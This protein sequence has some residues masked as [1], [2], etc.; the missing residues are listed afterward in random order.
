M[1]KWF[2]GLINLEHQIGRDREAIWGMK[3]LLSTHQ[4]NYIVVSVTLVWPIVKTLLW[5][6]LWHYKLTS[7]AVTHY[8]QYHQWTLFI[9]RSRL[10]FYFMFRTRLICFRNIYRLLMALVVYVFLNFS[11]FNVLYKSYEVNNK[12]IDVLY[13]L[14]Y[15]YTGI[16]FVV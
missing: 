11:Y 3:R 10:L 4:F 5:L 9:T 14:M 8:H 12:I 7:Y 13:I 15:C 6:C 1:L 16:L 2:V